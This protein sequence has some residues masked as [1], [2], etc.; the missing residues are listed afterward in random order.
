MDILAGDGGHQI[1][2]LIRRGLDGNDYQPAFGDANIDQMSFV[3]AN[4]VGETLWNPKGETIAPF[5]QNGF[6]DVDTL[7]ILAGG[8]R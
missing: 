4:L 6:H 3:H 7:M 2:E 8:A 5:L 1:S